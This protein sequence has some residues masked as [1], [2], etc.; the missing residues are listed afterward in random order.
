MTDAK[1]VALDKGLATTFN[2]IRREYSKIEA[3][4]SLSLDANCNKI[5]SYRSYSRMW[6][7]SVTR[8][9]R[10]IKSVNPSETLAKQQRNSNETLY[11]LIILQKQNATKQQ[12]NSNETL[13]K[14]KYKEQEQE[15]TTKSK[16]PTG[17]SEKFEIFWTA[18][19]NKKGKYKAFGS[20]KKHNCENGIFETLMSSLEK[21]KQDTQ[22]TKEDG[23]YIPHGS[24]WVNGRHWEDET[25][26]GGEWE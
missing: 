3:M 15:T 16:K 1:W 21:Q 14:H 19:P 9:I 20:W 7:W 25:H 24:T 11:S 10:F 6:S 4:Y 12:R 26:Q 22:W 2:E 5:R 23:K 13:A 17:Y 8:V 18:Y